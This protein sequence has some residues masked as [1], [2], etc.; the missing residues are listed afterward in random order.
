M[1]GSGLCGQTLADGVEAV[2]SHTGDMLR[3]IGG[4]GQSEGN[5]KGDKVHVGNID[6][7]FGGV[8]GEF[9]KAPG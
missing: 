8:E 6:E 7:E 5:W 4:V 3:C 2:S 1:V 9:A